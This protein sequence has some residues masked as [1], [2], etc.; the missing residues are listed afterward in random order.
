MIAMDSV[1]STNIKAIGFEGE[2]LAIQFMNGSLFHYPGAT[3]QAHYEKMK[4]ALLKGRYFAREI[5][6]DK[7]L[8][9]EKIEPA[10]KEPT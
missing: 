4:A 7:T 8:R 5:R 3:A 10:P 6:A 9:G 1:T 2:T